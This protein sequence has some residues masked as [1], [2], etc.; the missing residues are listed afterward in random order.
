MSH[1]RGRVAGVPVHIEHDTTVGGCCACGKR[2]H[3]PFAVVRGGPNGPHQLCV[4]CY[5][6]ANGTPGL[7][8]RINRMVARGLPRLPSRKCR[9]KPDDGDAILRWART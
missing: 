8:L 2:L 4:G 7:K 6:R 5:C 9:I 3:K 1:A